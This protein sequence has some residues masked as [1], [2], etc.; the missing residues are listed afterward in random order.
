MRKEKFVPGEY[1]HI[2]NRTIFNKPEFKDRK[3]I[4]RL[5]QSFILANSTKSS[6]AFQ[7]LR[8]NYDATVE[9]AIKII[10]KG[11]KLVDVLCYVIMPDHYHLLLKEKTEKGIIDFVRKCDI[12]ISKYINKKNNRKGPLFES[13]FK[14]KHI[15]TNQYLLHL[16]LYI[17]LNPLDFISDKTWRE[18]GLKD[19]EKEKNKLINFPWSSLKTFLN[20]NHKDLIISG[21]EIIT[22]Q[23]RGRK[24]YEEY[25]RSWSEDS[26][27]SIKDIL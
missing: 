21:Q 13:R 27:S 24:E 7:F 23:F 16:S 19:W 20:K 2:Y 11:K 4:A 18:H 5:Q 12:S 14:S 22:D 10:N 9:D 17:H 26:L 3:N 15:N 25:L 1:Y 8:N 6:E